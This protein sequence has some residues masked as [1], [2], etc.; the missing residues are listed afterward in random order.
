VVFEKDGIEFQ[1][2]LHS[3]SHEAGVRLQVGLGRDH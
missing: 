3:I 1:A 2:A